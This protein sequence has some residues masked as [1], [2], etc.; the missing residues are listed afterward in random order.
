M[1]DH[2]SAYISVHFNDEAPEA[3]RQAV[4]D[5]VL[6]A[7]TEAGEGAQA[8]QDPIRWFIVEA[9]RAADPSLDHAK[10]RPGT[11]PVQVLLRGESLPAS[12][13]ADVI[14][15]SFLTEQDTTHT[16]ANV[17][18]QLTVDPSRPPGGKFA[19]TS[20]VRS[21]GRLNSEAPLP[22]TGQGAGRD[23][24]GCRRHHDSCHHW[25]RTPDRSER[26]T[27]PVRVRIGA[28]PFGPSHVRVLDPRQTYRRR[29]PLCQVII[30]F[31]GVYRSQAR[32]L[33]G[34]LGPSAARCR[35]RG[36]FVRPAHQLRTPREPTM[37]RGGGA[38]AVTVWCRARGPRP[39]T[40]DLV[41][42]PS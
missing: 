1:S 40:K 20:E 3:A 18:A 6:A 27:A 11:S 38:A 12:R 16:V 35:I 19:F 10:P 28:A 2:A 34:V 15:R 7:F 33:R 9:S 36:Y 22:A 8:D 41:R 5:V 25:V 31:K 21:R 32:P 26:K 13:V 14:A 30:R 4:R 17:Y 24:S 39:G 37:R 29:C 42:G 23:G